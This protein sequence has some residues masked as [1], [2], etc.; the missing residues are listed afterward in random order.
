VWVREPRKAFRISG[1]NSLDKTPP[2]IQRLRQKYINKTG[3]H[4][5]DTEMKTVD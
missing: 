3:L 1:A 5:T 2:V 4:K